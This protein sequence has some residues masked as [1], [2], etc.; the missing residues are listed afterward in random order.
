MRNRG[1]AQTR[2]PFG[3]GFS[4]GHLTMPLAIASLALVAT[5]TAVGTST[6]RLPLL[7]VGLLLL[8]GLAVAVVNPTILLYG[9]CA[10][11]PLNDLLPPGPAGTI[12]RIAG[13]V[14]FVGYLVR[15]P[16]SLRPGTIPIVGWLYVGW[17]L[18]S[19]LWAVDNDTSFDAW[20]SL[21]QLFA[22]TVLIASILATNPQAGRRAAVAYL[23]TA[24]VTAVVAIAPVVQGSEA[25]LSRAAA[26]GDQNPAGFAS[27]LVPVVILLMG[28]VQSRGASRA[29]RGLAS[30]ALVICIVAVGLS[31]TR[32]AWLGIA[33]ATMVWVGLRRERRQV[34][35][36][37][38]AA[39]GLVVLFVL[40][41][42]ASDFLLERTGTS[43]ASGGSGRTD[44]WEVGLKIYAS[45]PVLGVGFGNFPLAFTPNVIA[46]VAGA[47]VG[48]AGRDP[49]SVLLGAL[50]E[51]GF[52]G[53][54]LL[55]L[56]VGITLLRVDTDGFGAMIR[57][58]LI[59][60]IVESFFLE[61]LTRK[62]VWLFL[63]IALGLAAAR[64]L[65][66]A[67]DEDAA[68]GRLAIDS[69]SRPLSAR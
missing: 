25:Y 30:A 21:A 5:V 33:V 49:H 38:S 16:N 55:I 58:A 22:I 11:I 9:Y 53:A 41:P 40:V 2:R 44:I 69:P 45:A 52:I 47:N 37:A 6:D 18:A 56:F 10:A 31:G 51:T 27:L 24:S 7:L 13:L 1:F 32:S 26:F 3:A 66:R 48:G 59:G 67:R 34:A 61:T 20:L 57:A 39:I 36:V 43:V 54:V 15:S 14:F 8:L 42:G 60:L 65:E 68:A 28:E 29:V 17:A 35:A 23:I 64:R 46:Q 12:G 19:T 4:A 63:A 62:H 50:A